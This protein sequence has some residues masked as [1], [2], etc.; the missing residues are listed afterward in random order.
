[1]SFPVKVPEK[2]IANLDTAGDGW[3]GASLIVAAFCASMKEE[4]EDGRY[5]DLGFGYEELKRELI[6]LEDIFAVNV[7]L[8]VWID[9]VVGFESLC[10]VV[11]DE[12]TNVRAQKTYSLDIKARYPDVSRALTG[13]EGLCL[14]VAVEIIDSFEEYKPLNDSLICFA[15]T[16][17]EGECRMF[18]SSE[19][20][21]ENDAADLAKMIT[22]FMETLFIGPH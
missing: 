8:R 22:A 21:R 11:A 5:I 9:N 14:P 3:G 6:G 7:P 4:R 19:V 16:P 2:L 20:F 17:V 1:L 13:K 10:K 12:L 18:Y 15:V